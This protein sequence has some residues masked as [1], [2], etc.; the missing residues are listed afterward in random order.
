M[1]VN[2]QVWFSG[3]TFTSLLTMVVAAIA[4]LCCHCLLTSHTRGEEAQAQAGSRDRDWEPRSQQ[5][6][7]TEK[8]KHDRSILQRIPED[9]IR[10]CLICAWCRL[11][12]IFV[13]VFDFAVLLPSLVVPGFCTFLHATHTVTRCY[14][15]CVRERCTH[16]RFL[17]FL[18][19]ALLQMIIQET[20]RA[21]CMCEYC[22]G[23][24]CPIDL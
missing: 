19:T 9:M 14:R 13:V 18:I 20:D 12:V 21:S 3:C 11:T 5:A 17:S 22:C 2:S 4:V 1:M 10:L 7:D 24:Q 16:W 8:Y 23:C 15:V 6:A